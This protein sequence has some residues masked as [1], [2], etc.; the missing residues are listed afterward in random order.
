MLRA[1]CAG[2]PQ[3]MRQQYTEQW[4]EYK[5]KIKT[6]EE[7]V[8]SQVWFIACMQRLQAALPETKN[9]PGMMCLEA[10]GTVGV[11]QASIK[12]ASV[13]LIDSLGGGHGSHYLSEAVCQRPLLSCVA[14]LFWC[15]ANRVRLRGAA[16]QYV[17]PLLPWRGPVHALT[18][19]CVPRLLPYAREIRWT[20]WKMQLKPLE[21]FRQCVLNKCS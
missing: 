19:L 7:L 15:S 21:K 1:K 2:F 12:A 17:L 10:D 9:V 8:D 6:W 11:A 14:R 20:N 13:D 4:Q 3:K 5:S 16:C 18:D